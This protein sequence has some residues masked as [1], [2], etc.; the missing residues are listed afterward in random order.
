MRGDVCE[1]KRGG[2]DGNEKCGDESEEEGESAT[3]EGKED[4]E[5]NEDEYYDKENRS[6]HD[7]IDEETQS[8]KGEDIISNDQ[9]EMKGGGM[10]EM[11]K[12]RSALFRPFQS[13][14]D[15]FSKHGKRKRKLINNRK[16]SLSV[17]ELRNG[18]DKCDGMKIDGSAPNLDAYSECR[19]S[20][21]E[22]EEDDEG[23]CS[24]DDIDRNDEK[25]GEIGEGV[26]LE[27]VE[28]GVEEGVEEEGTV[29]GVAEMEGKATEMIEEGDDD[30]DDDMDNFASEKQI[31]DERNKMNKHICSSIKSDALED[32]RKIENFVTNLKNKEFEL[33]EIIEKQNIEMI[34]LSEIIISQPGDLKKT[35]KLLDET[36]EENNL[37]ELENNLIITDL[38]KN[39][40]ELIESETQ[41][42]VLLESL[43]TEMKE[44]KNSFDVLEEE[45]YALKMLNERLNTENASLLH[46]SIEYDSLVK[47]QFLLEEEHESQNISMS[48]MI[49][50]NENLL[51]NL[52]EI[53]KEN[54]EIC[55][56]NSK[57]QNEIERLSYQNEILKQ[58]IIDNYRLHEKECTRLLENQYSEL[59]KIKKLKRK[60]R[61]LAE[62][63]NSKSE[64]WKNEFDANNDNDTVLN[65]NIDN[66]NNNNNEFK[67]EFKG[68][69][70]NFNR[71][72]NRT[73]LNNECNQDNSINTNSNVNPNISNFSS[74]NINET[75][76]LRINDREI[77]VRDAQ[78]NVSSAHSTPPIHPP[79]TTFSATPSTTPNTTPNTCP[80]SSS[81]I[82]R[83]SSSS[84][85]SSSNSSSSSFPN[86]TLSPTST[87]NPTSNS[88]STSTSRRSTLFKPLPL[89]HHH[90]QI[91]NESVNTKAT[92]EN[93][94]LNINK[95]SSLLDVPFHSLTF[96]GQQQRR[97]NQYS[98]LDR[99]AYNN[100]LDNQEECE[101]FNKDYNRI[102]NEY[103]IGNGNGNG[104]DNTDESENENKFFLRDC[105]RDDA[106][107]LI[108]CDRVP[109]VKNDDIGLS[110]VSLKLKNRNPCMTK[111]NDD[112]E[113]DLHGNE[114]GRSSKNNNIEVNQ[115]K[116]EDGDNHGSED[117]VGQRGSSS[118]C[119]NKIDHSKTI[120]TLNN[121]IK[122]TEGGD[123]KVVYENN[124]D[125]NNNNDTLREFENEIEHSNY[126][127]KDSISKYRALSRTEYEKN[128]CRK[129]STK[130]KKLKNLEIFR[131]LEPK[132]G[133]QSDDEVEDFEENLNVLRNE[134][135]NG[136]K[137]KKKRE[138]EA[139]NVDVKEGWQ[140]DEQGDTENEGI[141][142]RDI[143]IE[144]K[145]RNEM[146]KIEGEKQVDGE[147]AEKRDGEE[148]G[149]Y[150]Y[151]TTS[152]AY[153]SITQGFNNNMKTFQNNG[154]DNN[155]NNNNNININP[156]LKRTQ[157]LNSRGD[158]RPST[159]S[160]M[161]DR[162]RSSN[163]SAYD[164]QNLGSVV[165][166]ELVPV[167]SRD[168]TLY[169]SPLPYN[170]PHTHAQ[171]MTEKQFLEWSLRKKPSLDS[172]KSSSSSMDQNFLGRKNSSRRKDSTL[173]SSQQLF[174]KEY[175]RSKRLESFQLND[176]GEL[177]L[178]TPIRPKTGYVKGNRYI[179]NEDIISC[180]DSFS[181]SSP[182]S[183][184]SS[185]TPII[186]SKSK[187][188]EGSKGMEKNGN[189]NANMNV[190]MDNTVNVNNNKNMS[191]S[192]SM[193][194]TLPSELPSNTTEKILRKNTKNSLTLAP[195]IADLAPNLQSKISDYAL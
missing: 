32:I 109:T 177:S 77:F 90:E 1:W 194:M 91:R 116:E 28:K 20:N 159:E 117:N 188:I 96:N 31:C 8:N 3:E 17:L 27:L 76:L 70:K 84:S 72:L 195:N 12:S 114:K 39:L 137:K 138:R 49:I 97:S 121:Y 131:D 6:K 124:H 165:I 169:E 123:Y 185:I 65:Y 59:I 152:A 60:N 129:Y 30:D 162:K 94:C 24:D 132:S 56:Y 54:K 26:E 150:A 33:I 47:R 170:Q 134:K 10:I 168:K 118:D 4:D 48:N 18:Q 105:N 151:S 92:N 95:S 22:M 179:K 146:K 186:I 102:E 64:C 143:Q 154:N 178:L 164:R 128:I 148:D 130:D 83:S 174:E 89:P 175:S 127:K 42:T 93:D 184:F 189:M 66:N 115:R 173:S 160:S 57:I 15:L 147:E 120:N 78:S 43:N 35:Q 112:L 68:H 73:N 126:N 85:S 110:K 88:T 14:F 182:S 86:P 180:Q 122:E 41:K 176:R 144:E 155:N 166:P 25:E 46:K 82:L 183:F 172:M 187:R 36:I 34:N 37:K 135:E 74:R 81:S 167:P 191:M 11:K 5:E 157:N 98:S 133:I 38:E 171:H 21:N 161:R 45:E 141:E 79:P 23:E 55:I 52:D 99:T 153:P 193:S 190:N 71:N 107:V 142:N 44:L 53:K 192:M 156:D 149:T 67:N 2:G 100:K 13:P 16:K 145:K 29:G 139:V 181:K 87:S 75:V 40:T 106:V 80:S 7:D 51:K 163:Y 104:N 101:I 62:G 119:D 158:R 61:K 125:Y 108:E 136:R 58:A 111:T 140:H 113:T 9:N 103:Q 69:N 63:M 19:D 50:E